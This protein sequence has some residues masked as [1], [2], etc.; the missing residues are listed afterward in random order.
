LNIY[1]DSP[2][3]RERVKVAAARAGVTVSE[4]CQESIRRRLEQEGQLPASRETARAAAGALDEIRHRHR[5]LGMP[6]SELIAE[7][8]RR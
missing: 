2:R 3:F 6:V 4:Y 5:Q 1:V 8:R 7:G